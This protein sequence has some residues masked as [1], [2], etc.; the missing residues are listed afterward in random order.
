MA[1]QMPEGV[2]VDRTGERPVRQDT[3]GVMRMLHD[4]LAEHFAAKDR[5]VNV[6]GGKMQGLMDTVDE[7][8]KGAPDPGSEEY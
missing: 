2:T 6:G 4:E 8:V 3:R 1:D 7:A 5:K